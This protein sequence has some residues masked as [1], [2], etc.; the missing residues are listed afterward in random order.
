T[1]GSASTRPSAAMIS[2]RST[3]SGSMRDRMPSR[4]SSTV[5]MRLT[6]LHA[7]GPGSESECPG[8]L[9]RHG[10]LNCEQMVRTIVKRA[11]RSPGVLRLRPR[12]R[13]REELVTGVRKVEDGLEVAEE[14]A[15]AQH[16]EREKAGGDRQ[17]AKTQRQPRAR[18]DGRKDQEDALEED[19]DEAENRDHHERGVSLG[20]PARES[21]QQVDERDHPA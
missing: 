16:E 5:N 21:L 18:R 4:A 13:A 14:P 10:D 19:T 1:I 3:P 11:R 20:R 2:T 12:S 9:C 15:V 7:Q 8:D 17:V 6:L